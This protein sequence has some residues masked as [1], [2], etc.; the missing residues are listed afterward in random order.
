[1]RVVIAEDDALLREGLGLILGNQGYEVAA[2]VGDAEAFLEAVEECDPDIA[3]VDV[4]MPPTHTDEGVR[5]AVR[6]RRDRPDLAVVV[7]SA[8]VEQSF[9]TDLLAEGSRKVGYLLKERVGRVEAFTEALRRVAE[10]GTAIDP[11]VVSQ[12]FARRRASDAL[13][14]LSERERDVL[15]AMA[16]GFGNSAI[17]K[18]LFVTENTVHKHIRSIF[19]K[20]GLSPDDDSDRRVAAVLKYLDGS[21]P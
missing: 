21:R 9:A 4:R 2:A 16:E 13:A 5:A 10:G 20:L 18:R 14:D 1:M 19:R 7:L 17:A 6:A 11:E 3:V 15:A 8:Y 12:L